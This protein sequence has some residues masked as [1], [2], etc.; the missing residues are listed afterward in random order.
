MSWT[1]FDPSAE[2][3]LAFRVQSVVDM[4]AIAL[5]VVDHFA[6]CA[7]FTRHGMAMDMLMRLRLGLRLRWSPLICKGTIVNQ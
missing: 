4:L 1:P 3:T 2:Q 6:R 5:F 7:R